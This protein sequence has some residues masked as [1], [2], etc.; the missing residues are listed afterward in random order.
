MSKEKKVPRWMPVPKKAG[1]FVWHE[2]TC[3]AYAGKR[4]RCAAKFRGEV[5]NSETKRPAKSVRY[6]N[7][8]EAAGWVADTRR[9]MEAPTPKNSGGITV[10]ELWRLFLAAARNG[11][12]LR[13]GGKRYAS[14]TLDKYARDYRHHVKP[15]AGAKNT[16]A[17]DS[18]AWQ[19][20]V[21]A[22][23]T[24][25]QRDVNGDPIGAEFGPM[26]VNTIMAGIRAAYRWATD[27]TEAIVRD[28]ALKAVRIPKGGKPKRKR[29]AAPE[30]I[31]T[32][33]D[34]FLTR[35][36]QRGPVPNPAVRIA[37]A[38][39]FYAGLR[40]SEVCALDWADVELARDGGWITVGESKSEAGTERRIP[41]AAPLARILTEWRGGELRI[42]PVCTGARGVRVTDS[43]VASA[44]VAAWKEA[45]LPTYAPHEARHTFASA[46]IANRDVSLA[47]LKEWLGH[48]SLATTDAYVKTLP[49]YRS[50]SAG[51][52]ISGAFG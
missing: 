39:M 8:N 28:N 14:R 44:G 52:R 46:V 2:A 4:C 40:V 27:P 47:D 26:T 32:L 29:V 12:A 16:D 33:L 23:I 51:A 6:D 41:I 21:T 15:H 25:G 31:P 42:G 11:T 36:K 45:G 35:R 3:G 1:V 7:V 5:W 49:G 43:G 19:A 17:M 9:G 34:A 37:W 20:V 50:E 48:A 38:I 22:I 13:K 18:R 24:T 10:D 30:T